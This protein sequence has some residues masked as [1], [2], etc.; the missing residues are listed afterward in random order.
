MQWRHDTS[1]ARYVIKA[2]GQVEIGSVRAIGDISSTPI[3]EPAGTLCACRER[4]RRDELAA[5]P[6][7]QTA[8]TFPHLQQ[9]VDSSRRGPTFQDRANIAAG[10]LES[11]RLCN[12]RPRW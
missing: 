11:Y 6:C 2:D 3:I 1:I 7:K 9:D 8:E 12:T 5:S 4:P 10:G